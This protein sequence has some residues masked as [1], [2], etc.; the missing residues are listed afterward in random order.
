[1]SRLSAKTFHQ[2]CALQSRLLRYG[3]E[4]LAP[5]LGAS[6]VG[7][8]SVLP[9]FF[10]S[11]QETLPTRAPFD[12][13]GA[14]ALSAANPFFSTEA[15]AR[16]WVGERVC[17]KTWPTDG[18]FPASRGGSSAAMWLAKTG[19]GFEEAATLRGWCVSRAGVERPPG[20]AAGT[21]GVY[22][23]CGGGRGALKRGGVS[24]I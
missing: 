10:A 21:G 5:L 8:D 1:M 23:H 11:H 12:S 24:R 14:S 15:S 18:A 2:K 20:G 13:P 4:T 6:L 9:D 22:I 7:N 16:F 3:D 17:V 19:W